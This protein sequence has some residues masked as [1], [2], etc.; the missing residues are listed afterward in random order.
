M[1]LFKHK[2]KRMPIPYQ[3]HIAIGEHKLEQVDQIKYLGVIFDEKLSWKAHVKHLCSKL[4]SGS[5]T[6]LKLRNYVDIQT[7]KTAC[8]SLIYSHL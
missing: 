7:L 6:L 1:K 8:Y 5:W 4:S 3:H 2:L